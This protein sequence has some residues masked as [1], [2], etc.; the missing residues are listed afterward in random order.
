MDD[1]KDVVVFFHSPCWDGFAAAHQLYQRYPAAEF[2]PASYGMERPSVRL[3]YVFC[4]D[5]S[6]P[7]AELLK[8]A[9]EA[10]SLF[11][12]DHHSTAQEDLKGFDAECLRMGEIGTRVIF[13]MN[14]SG[15][16]I[17]WEWL[18]PNDTDVPWIIA[19]TESRDLWTF[20]SPHS[21]ERSA[22][23]RSYPMEFE[24]WDRLAN[25]PPSYLHKIDAEGEA[26]LRREQQIITDHIGRAVTINLAG[27]AIP[28]VNATCLFSDIAGELAKTAPFAA[29]WFHRG[30]GRFQWS[31]RSADGGLDVSVI[32]KTFGGGGHVHAAGF[33]SF[34]L[35]VSTDHAAIFNPSNN[36]RGNRV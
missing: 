30:D 16:R 18:H 17:T 10:V 22:V 25:I 35:D 20:A 26:I 9:K 34:G 5:F 6:F 21:R 3:K 31:L 4:V 29:C 8:M 14:K 24:M 36:K 28:A 7:R 23:I 32:A 15:G 11:V 13:D 27:H 12:F 19:A 33:T 1:G 2:I